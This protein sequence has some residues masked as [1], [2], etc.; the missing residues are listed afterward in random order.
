A[1]PCSIAAATGNQQIPSPI[2]R[3]EAISILA[4]I[5]VN[6]LW[7]GAGFQVV[8]ISRVLICL[9][10]TT[11]LIILARSISGAGLRRQPDGIFFQA[12]TIRWPIHGRCLA[13]SNGK[14]A[15]WFLITMCGM[16]TAIAL[17]ASRLL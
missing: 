16:R 3:S 17:W 7:D 15:D 9:I 8:Q 6:I 14:G 2:T 4:A 13:S 11:R 12:A 1:G 5:T 10:Q